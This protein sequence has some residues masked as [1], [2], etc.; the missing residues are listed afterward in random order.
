MLE[1]GVFTSHFNSIGL[2]CINL[3]P[4]IFG[5]SSICWAPGGR[6]DFFWLVS[7]VFPS[8]SHINKTKPK[9]NLEILK[10]CNV[11][12]LLLI[13]WNMLA[14]SPLRH[15]NSCWRAYGALSVTAL[16]VLVIDLDLET[17]THFLPII[18]V[19]LKI[20]VIDLQANTFTCRICT[21]WHRDLDLWS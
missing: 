18:L 14:L 6:T 11:L 16:I 3:I 9:T 8:K 7:P 17:G 10:N 1:M 13:Q 2:S 12:D 15:G 19:F 21:T 5:H 20:F 4:D